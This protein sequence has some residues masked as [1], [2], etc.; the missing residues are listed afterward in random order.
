MCPRDILIR[1][2]D[3]LR[4][5]KSIVNCRC[6]PFLTQ[7]LSVPVLQGL[8][9]TAWGL[10]VWGHLS[11]PFFQKVRSLSPAVMHAFQPQE[12]QQ[13]YQVEL[14]L[15]LEAPDLGLDTSHIDRY[16]ALF[17]GKQVCVSSS[18]RLHLLWCAS[19]SAGQTIRYSIQDHPMLLPVCPPVCLSVHLSVRRCLMSDDMCVCSSAGTGSVDRGCAGQVAPHHGPSWPQELCLPTGASSPPAHAMH[20]RLVVCT[21]ADV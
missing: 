10:A 18:S 16:E 9:N 20:W 4:R 2:R 13:L 19:T 12:L 17:A 5:Q 11:T 1:S 15:R 3:I 8:A 7:Y 21:I 6:H 14:I